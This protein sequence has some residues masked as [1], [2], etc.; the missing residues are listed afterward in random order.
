MP[1]RDHPDDK[2]DDTFRGPPFFMAD[3][4]FFQAGKTGYCPFA[5]TQRRIDSYTCSKDGGSKD[6][7]TYYRRTAVHDSQRIYTQN[8]GIDGKTDSQ[9]SKPCMAKQLFFI[10][11]YQD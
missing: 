7:D 2:E 8:T 5:Y 3:V 11:I 1:S 6:Q 9:S 10:T 4:S